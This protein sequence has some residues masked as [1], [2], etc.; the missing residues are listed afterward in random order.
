MYPS[1][2]ISNTL[3]EV[4]AADGKSIFAIA[5]TE[6]YA[7]VT[8]FFNGGKEETLLNETSVL[9][10]SKETKEYANHPE[11]PAGQITQEVL[12]SLKRSPCDF[13]LINFANADMVGHTGNF[14]ATI[15]AV[16]YLDKQ[17]GKLYRRVVEKMDGTIYI[18]ADH[19]NAEVMYDEKA[20]QPRTAHTT[21]PV[22]FIMLRKDLK[23][24]GDELLPLTQLADIAPFILKNMGL[25]IPKEMQR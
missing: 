8:Y 7:H 18:T 13:Y 19:G 3:K 15:Q 22:P 6:K 21:N 5:E 11:I 1:Q 23:G 12:K 9:I 14:G 17:L 24:K 20:N 2:R 16:E 25:P 10:T 4:L